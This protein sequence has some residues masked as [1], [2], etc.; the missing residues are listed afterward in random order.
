[1]TRL[2]VA[3]VLTAIIHMINTLIYSV[4][5]AGVNT[6]RLAIAYSLFNVIF[7]FASTANMILAPL[8]SSIVEHAIQRAAN[9]R[10]DVDITGIVNTA[11]YQQELAALNHDIRL[12]IL[13]ATV[14]T[15][16]G[17]MFIPA[18]VRIFVRAIILFD[19][20]KSVPKMMFMV[21]FSPRRALNLARSIH[22]PHRDMVKRVREKT[23]IPK[24]FLW[25]NLV[26]NAVF[27]TGVL[28]AM[29]AGALFPEFRATSIVL[30]GLV[31]GIATLMFVMVVDPTAAMITD[32][33]MRGERDEYD[34]KQMSFYLAITR[35]G[36]TI[37]AQAI[38][39]PAAMLIQYT[40]M[41]IAHPPF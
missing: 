33:A 18:F 26:A 39:I 13:A 10:P 37:L 32:Q 36:G 40:A 16:I 41:F 35:L 28:S 31:N 20:V 15:L 14:G 11:V 25:F 21:L 27:T 12:V 17:I 4:R 3:V 5:P 30:S 29:Y 2:L 6:K 22:L 24:G 34:V 38:F 8:L 9:A 19:E 7:L 23:N 1:M